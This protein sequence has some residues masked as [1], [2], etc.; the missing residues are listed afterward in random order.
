MNGQNKPNKTGLTRLLRAAACSWK[1]FRYIWKSEEAFRQEVLF[2]IFFIPL[3]LF[4][5]DGGTERA[6]LI[7]S[8]LLI[9]LVEVLNSAIECTIDRIGPEFHE[10]SG[11]A[12]DLGS[13]AVILSICITVVVWGLVLWP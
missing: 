11:N 10:L 2:C 5:G 3:G 1:G 9:P 12:K 4:L 7:G 13:S 6:L 8:I